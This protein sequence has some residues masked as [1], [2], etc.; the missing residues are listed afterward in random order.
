MEKLGTVPEDR[1]GAVVH[2]EDSHLPSFSEFKYEDLF[3]KNE[4]PFVWTIK[5][6]KAFL[7]CE[8]LFDLPPI[9]S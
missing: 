8:G 6:E 3:S 4:T 9:S 7:V 1:S 5:H 2:R